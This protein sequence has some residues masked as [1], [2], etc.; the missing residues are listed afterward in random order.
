MREPTIEGKQ[1]GRKEVEQA[2]KL[3]KPHRSVVFMTLNID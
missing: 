1:A 2:V 3:Y